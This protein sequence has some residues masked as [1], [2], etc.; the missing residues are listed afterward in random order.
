MLRRSLKGI[1]SWDGGSSEDGKGGREGEKEGAGERT[2]K[3]AGKVVA[4]IYRWHDCGR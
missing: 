2:F 1:V 4:G 3:V